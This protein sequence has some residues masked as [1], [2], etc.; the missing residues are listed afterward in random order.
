MP[1]RDQQV[2]AKERHKDRLCKQC[3]LQG[4]NTDSELRLSPDA[5]SFEMFSEHCCMS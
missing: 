1:P 4:Q 5:M 3:K 2:C